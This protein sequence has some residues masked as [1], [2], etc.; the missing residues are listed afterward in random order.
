[1]KSLKYLLLSISIFIV[2]AS[3]TSSV[4]AAPDTAEQTISK[5]KSSRN[6]DGTDKQTEPNA[7]HDINPSSAEQVL[8][9]EA[10]IET[11]HNRIKELLAELE[12]EEKSF[13]KLSSRLKKLAAQKKEKELQLSSLGDKT[14]P[15]AQ[16]LQLEIDNASKDY[17]LFKQQL[18]VNLQS[19]RTL[20]A[21]IRGLEEKIANDKKLLKALRGDEKPE[22][23]TPTQT[24]P[25]TTTDA[26]KGATPEIRTPITIPSE[27][28]QAATEKQQEIE[29]LATPE[30]I[31]AQK[32]EE[33]KRAEAKQAEKI[34]VEFVE[35]KKALEDQI[36]REQQLLNNQVESRANIEVYLAT[37]E[38]KQN[39]ADEKGDQK[40][41]NLLQQEKLKALKKLRKLQQEIVSRSMLLNQL[42]Q[43]LSDVQEQQLQ[44]V[45]KA[46]DKRQEAEQARQKN[47]WLQSPLHPHNIAQWFVTRGPRVLI[48]IAFMVLLLFISGTSVKRVAKVVSVKGRGTAEGRANRAETIALS[49]D[50]VLRL[51]IYVGG[52]FL[53]LEE[54]GVD[55][56]T[57][58]GG[59]AI[60]G[61]AFAFGAQNLMRD[62]FSG[63]M[64]LLEDQYELGDVV[65]V[66]NVTGVVERVNMRATVLRDLEGRVHFIPNGEIKQVTNRTYEWAQAVFDINVSYK[67]NVDEVM[68]LLM[69]LAR[70]LQQEPEFKDD[71]LSDPVMLGVDKFGDA[72]VTIK[73]IIKTR[74]NRMWPIRRELLRRIKNKFDEVGIQ[75]PVPQREV[76]QNAPA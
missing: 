49:M 74:G 54:A 34:V 21:Q 33:E 2:F 1:M 32:E 42:H 4:S 53:V 39:I 10:S 22:P 63:I 52:T 75:I 31:E 16:T 71:I 15:A 72:A 30:Q 51:L 44:A 24:Q 7:G 55:I 67:E 27:P 29:A 48:V 11:D 50:A 12:E 56:K 37:L 38:E 23:T 43:Q 41:A 3:E 18:D 40:E 26:A 59:A 68:T 57:I 69:D 25:P 66:G 28:P 47:V 61:L 46:E 58:L 9:I 13:T 14:S 20:K 8:K 36:T 5:D 76:F 45:K 35:R 73:F 62:Y 60:I 6:P 64:I 17:E 65:T 70:Q 19:Q